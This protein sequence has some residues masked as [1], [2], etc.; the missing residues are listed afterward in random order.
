MKLTATSERTYERFFEKK[1]IRKN[2]KA[3]YC[4]WVCVQRHR[5]QQQGIHADLYID[6]QR[7]EEEVIERRIARLVSHTNAKLIASGTC[8]STTLPVQRPELQV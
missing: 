8:M 7:I 4:L 2:W 3:S 5:F 6:G 1:S